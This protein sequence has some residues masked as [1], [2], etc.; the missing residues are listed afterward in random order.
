MDASYYKFPKGISDSIVNIDT[1]YA[2]SGCISPK[3]L[4]TFLYGTGVLLKSY[5][6][7][8]YTNEVLKKLSQGELI[9]KSE[10]LNYKSV[11]DDR[12]VIYANNEFVE[13][14]TNYTYLYKDNIVKVSVF[15]EE[16]FDNRK[17]ETCS[18]GFYTP[19]SKECVDTEFLEFIS[20]TNDPKVFLLNQEYGDYVFT[21]FSVS[22]PSTFDLELNYGKEFAKVNAKMI[23]SLNSNHSGLYMFHGPPGTGKTTYIKYLASELKKD[24]IFFPTSLVGDLTNPSIVNLLTKKQNCVLILEDAEKAITKR[25]VNSDSSLVSTLL[26]MTDGILG[27]VLK[28]NVIVTYNCSRQDLDEA[29]LR[30]GRLKAEHT[31]DKLSIENVKKIAKKLKLNID[32]D[33]EMTLAEIF[34]YKK[35]EELIG[36]RS[37]LT[38]K[39]AIG[40]GSAL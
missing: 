21:K 26:N 2:C 39:P 30:K 8:F 14:D 1:I 31:F 11:K 27:D 37:A 7:S 38:K 16:G 35:D 40:F 4:L 19:L 10:T 9:E 13:S 36:N 23:E 20:N 15:E 3:Y 34:N 6:D 33:S 29:L 5:K 18:L 22:L 12:T 32:I 28:L 24:V 17:K 25:E